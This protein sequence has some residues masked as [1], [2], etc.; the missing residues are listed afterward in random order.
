MT[1]EATGNSQKV[2][3]HLEHETLLKE[4]EVAQQHAGMLHRVSWQATGIL[5]VGI[6][7]VSGFAISLRQD[8]GGAMIGGFFIGSS[9]AMIAWLFI[10]RRLVFFQRVTYRRMQEIEQR[11]GMRRQVYISLLDSRYPTS[12]AAWKL[13][14]PNE[15]ENFNTHVRRIKGCCV[16]SSEATFTGLWVFLIIVLLV[17]GVLLLAGFIPLE[18]I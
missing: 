18:P 15:Q 12:E 5:V 13:L 2:R 3:E 11:L 6:G 8:I 7:A 16:F 10:V 14:S 17:V 9:L 4:Y 1:Q